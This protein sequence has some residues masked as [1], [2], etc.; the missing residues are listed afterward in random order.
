MEPSLYP[1]LSR[2]CK[3]ICL[4]SFEETSGCITTTT[5]TTS[6]CL[7]LTA[8]PYFQ[9]DDDDETESMLASEGGEVKVAQFK[10]VKL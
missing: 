2:L 10:S 9:N 6:Y 5:A 1:N 4:H 8:L 7:T 3:T